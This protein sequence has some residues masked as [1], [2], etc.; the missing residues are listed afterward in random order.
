MSFFT[1]G[2]TEMITF[3]KTVNGTHHAL[4]KAYN[5]IEIV[6]HGGIVKSY[7]LRLYLLYPTLLPGS[8]RGEYAF[9]IVHDIFFV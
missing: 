1:I 6:G 8:F 9:E 4:V 2:R 7:V 5:G 3:Y